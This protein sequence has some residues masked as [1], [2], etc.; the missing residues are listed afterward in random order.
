MKGIKFIKNFCARRRSVTFF[1]VAALV[2]VPAGT[3]RVLCLDNSC[4]AQTSFSS[5]TPFC[6][7]PVKLRRLVE[8][9]FYDGRSPDIM[10]VTGST[11]VAGGGGFDGV[12]F[13]PVW[14]STALP[15]GGRVPLV[16]A[17]TGVARDAEVPNG[18]GLDD[19]SETIADIID[20]RRPHPAVRSGDPVGRVASGEV[21]RVVME[22]V[23]KGIGSDD[24]E[25]HRQDWPRLRRLMRRGAGTLDAEVGSLPLD[26]A[27]TIAT[28]GTG[29]VP[30]RH[31]IIGALLRSDQVTY[32]LTE[33]HRADSRVVRAWQGR[34]PS[35]VIAS[36]GDDL[37]EERKQRPVVGVVGTD[38]ADRSLI[39]GSWYPDG[40]R[41]KAV[42]LGRRASVGEQID[43]ARRLLTQGAFG[44][45]PNTDLVGV[46]LSGT[47][48]EL[49]RALGQLVEVTNRVSRGS[50]AIVVTAT[51]ASSPSKTE[52]T[53]D[54]EA[55]RRRLTR[56]LPGS[57]PLIEALVPGGLY[58]DQKALARLKLSDDVVLGELLAMRG[59]TG[60]LLMADAFP[61]IAVTFARYC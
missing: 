51:G 20:L 57:P 49:D 10:A 42:I 3:V 4:E 32:S 36:L 14:P 23:W 34:A 30:N 35:A 61:A 21:P 29:G 54:A 59:P 2:G 46:V 12:N 22:V 45:D 56:S 6:S 47:I 58:L 43:A 16:F 53:V 38:R 26:P 9:G 31:G 17:G 18:T 52:A 40:D 24:L 28:I 39:G 5:K 8:R 60:D 15:D 7:L 13:T 27:A 1:V 19:V 50:S 11:L 44:R 33:D 41:D 37:D 55:L 48:A 25:R